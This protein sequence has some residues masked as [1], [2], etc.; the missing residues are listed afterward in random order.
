VFIDDLAV[1]VRAAEALGMT[2][3]LHRDPAGTLANLAGLL[4]VPLR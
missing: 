4:G 1:N 2:G 3:I